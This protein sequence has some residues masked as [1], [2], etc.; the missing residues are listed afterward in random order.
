MDAFDA[1]ER[2]MGMKDATWARHANPWSVWT[3]FTCLP[4]LILAIWSRDWFGWYS[5]VPIA[6][7]CLWIW[8]NPRAFPVPASTDNWASKGTFGERIFLNR[9]TIPIPQHHLRWAYVL[10]FASAIG[11]PPLIWGLWTLDFEWTLIGAILTVL[12]KVW[13]VD[14]MVWLY[15]D[16]KDSDPTY[17]SWLR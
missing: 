10:G 17:Q 5:L 8:W 16:R 9:K 14:R 2:S 11:I 4:L 7:A 3:R 1:T 15:E 6:L 13:F 12:P